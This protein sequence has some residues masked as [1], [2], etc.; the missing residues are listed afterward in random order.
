MK[1]IACGGA[2]PS[3]RPGP[4]S[5]DG[6]GGRTFSVAQMASRPVNSST[7][8]SRLRRRRSS[9]LTTGWQRISILISGVAP[10]RY[11][12]AQDD[13][14]RNFRSS[15]VMGKRAVLAGGLKWI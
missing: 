14:T 12:Q 6:A 1:T 13:F 5:V 2:T 11:A 4:S 7:S 10:R 15:R 3:P 8:L 9:A